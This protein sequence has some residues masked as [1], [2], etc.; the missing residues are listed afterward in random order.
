MLA[1]FPTATRISARL[2]CLAL[3]VAV[4]S[5]RLAPE[6]LTMANIPVSQASEQ[7][8]WIEVGWADAEDAERAPVLGAAVLATLTIISC[9]A[10]AVAIWLLATGQVG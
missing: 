9:V 7:P 8:G 5:T 3:H 1:A 6:A 2:T 10:V 4:V